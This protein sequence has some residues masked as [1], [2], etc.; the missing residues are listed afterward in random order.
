MDFPAG[1]DGF[2]GLNQALEDG[3]GAG[4]VTHAQAKVPM[5]Q[6]APSREDRHGGAC[7]GHHCDALILDVQPPDS[8]E[9][10]SAV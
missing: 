7:R 8:R 10:V 9:H 3:R 2:R 1:T 6:R 4:G 5:S